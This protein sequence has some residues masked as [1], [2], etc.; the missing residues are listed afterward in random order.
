MKQAASACRHTFVHRNIYKKAIKKRVNGPVCIAL[1]FMQ[2]CAL[3]LQYLLN[4]SNLRMRTG[5]AC[6]VL[7]W[8]HL[9]RGSRWAAPPPQHCS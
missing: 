7:Q 9:A 6:E 4:L 1:I 8:L 3:A 5:H 2:K